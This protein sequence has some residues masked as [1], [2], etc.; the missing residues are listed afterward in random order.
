[1]PQVWP[2]KRSGEMIMAAAE[3][4]LQELKAVLRHTGP[5]TVLVATEA[6]R[7]IYEL[8]LRRK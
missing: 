1:M 2:Q 5:K 8:V 4:V 7:A 6:N 3:E